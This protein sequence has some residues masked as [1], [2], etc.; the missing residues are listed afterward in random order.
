VTVA[1]DA[2]S[3]GD[4]PLGPDRMAELVTLAR[5]D[6]PAERLGLPPG[7][8][9]QTLAARAVDL[10]DRWRAVAM[11]IGGRGAGRRARDVLDLLE[12][13][14]HDPD[15]HSAPD[16]PPA[17]A[18]PL[19]ELS[20]DSMLSS[21]DRERLRRLSEGLS[22][23]QR[24]GLSESADPRDLQAEAADLARRLRIHSQRSQSP[25]IRRALLQA[26]DAAESL[27]AVAL[28]DAADLDLQIS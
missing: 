3:R 25:T 20:A 26:L 6:A 1:L 13:L 14:A 12:E 11:S 15:G 9:G 17:R 18:F 22:P 19:E 21:E 7:S 24:L 4:L 23:A 8:P 5:H 16:A 27:Y 28:Q 2:A 10:A